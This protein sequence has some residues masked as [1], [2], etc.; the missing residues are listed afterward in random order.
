MELSRDWL[1]SLDERSAIIEYDG[2][3]SREEADRQ[4]KIEFFGLF[5]KGGENA[6]RP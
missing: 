4:A 2:N 6:K 1:V 5:W 3:A